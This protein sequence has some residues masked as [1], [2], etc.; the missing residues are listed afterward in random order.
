MPPPVVAAAAGDCAKRAFAAVCRRLLIDGGRRVGRRGY[1]RLISLGLLATMVLLHFPLPNQLPWRVA[2]GGLSDEV[3]FPCQHSA[4]G[5]R[6]ARQCYAH[7]CCHTPAQRRAFARRHGVDLESLGVEVPREHPVST[8]PPEPSG[9]RSCCA[10]DSRD[11]CSTAE[12]AET[13]AQVELDQTQPALE[14][15][16][17]AGLLVW[18]AVLRCQGIEAWMQLL[19]TGGWLPDPRQA[20]LPRHCDGRLSLSSVVAISLGYPPEPPPPRA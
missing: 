18:Q 6:T 13:A 1:R 15:A 11:A 3:P 9:T 20:D 4:C 12:P 5:C 16:V 19:Q 2:A 17:P 10:A 7:C 8:E 14:E